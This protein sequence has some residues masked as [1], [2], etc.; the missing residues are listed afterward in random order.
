M[1]SQHK[2][3]KNKF[4]NRHHSNRRLGSLGSGIC[5]GCSRLA[6][7]PIQLRLRSRAFSFPAASRAILPSWCPFGRLSFATFGARSRSPGFKVLARVVTRRSWWRKVATCNIFSCI[8]RR[9]LDRVVQIERA[10]VH[11][12]IVVTVLVTAAEVDNIVVVGIW[13]NTAGLCLLCHFLVTT[14]CIFN[15][16]QD[17][18]AIALH[19]I[20]INVRDCRKLSQVCLV[21]SSCVYFQERESIHF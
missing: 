2:G 9:I 8:A 19:F 14:L 16:S 17:L 20:L 10:L 13:N 5:S 6:G 12:Q 4:S 3:V 18:P 15:Q 7:E 11:K 1:T 21:V